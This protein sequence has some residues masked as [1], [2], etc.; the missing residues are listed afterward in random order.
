MFIDP[1]YRYYAGDGVAQEALIFV[2]GREGYIFHPFGVEGG[3]LL[4]G[5]VKEARA[6]KLVAMIHIYIL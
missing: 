6:F 3:S 5:E 4:A 1:S 2:G